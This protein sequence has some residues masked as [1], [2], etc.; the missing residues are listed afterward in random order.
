MI[1]SNVVSIYRVYPIRWLQLIV[2]ALATFANAFHS[3]TFASIATE[4]STFFDITL[5]QVNILGI[6]SLILYIPSTALAIWTHRRLSMRMSMSIAALINLG[7]WIRLFGLITPHQGYTALVIGQIFSALAGPFFMNL[8]AE[9]AGRW[10]A[11]EQRDIAT[12]ICSMAN[13]LGSAVGS[14]L[15][16]LFVIDGSSQQFFLL[17]TVEAAFT[18]LTTV[19]LIVI[20]K[21][22]PPSP[23][24]PSEEHE[25]P[26]VIKQD[27]VRLLTNRHYLA[28]LIGFSIGL[29]IAN[30]FITLLYQLI[31]PSGYSSTN[32]GIFSAI[33]LVTG[34]FSSILIGVILARTRAYRLILKLLLLGA[35]ASAAYFIIILRPNMQ[36]PL[37]VSIGLMG[38]FLLP[39]L[40][41]C[42]EC[43]AECTYP[44]H[45]EWSTGLLQCLGNVLGGIFVIVHGDLIKLAP[46][47][48]PDDILTPAS[49][50]IVC[51]FAVSAVAL[52]IYNGPYLRL[53]V[54]HEA[55]A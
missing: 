9:F 27:L 15:P 45:A 8:P 24:S 42:F 5:L 47:Y 7:V 49:I 35:C 17:L 39:L 34:I 3:I 53:Q 4:V 16:S 55:T 44:V 26:I 2:Y 18:T 21:S 32:A 10:F 25:Q 33:F 1:E 20:I 13:P 50:F 48:K 30:S 14:L 22:K 46:V 54:E 40:P 41:V 23:P 29:G 37:A 52:L 43:A 28:L 36:Y 51:T 31:Q 11:P 12:A 38:F 6:I 19:L